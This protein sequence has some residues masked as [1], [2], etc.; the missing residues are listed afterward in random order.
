MDAVPLLLVLVLKLK[1]PSLDFPIH[2]WLCNI[3][4]VWMSIWKMATRLKRMEITTASYWEWY[5]L[6]RIRIELYLNLYTNTHRERERE[7]TRYM[8]EMNINIH[9][10]IIAQSHMNWALFTSLYSV[11]PL[12]FYSKLCKA[13]IRTSV[14]VC[15]RCVWVCVRVFVSIISWHNLSSHYSRLSHIYSKC[16][17]A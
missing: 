1:T 5:N 12:V 14:H 6:K 9:W 17:V 8:F 10:S 7:K 2:I 4:V 13:I 3:D 16:S 11:F 15:V